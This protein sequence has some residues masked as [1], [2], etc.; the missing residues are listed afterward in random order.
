MPC[1][2]DP[3]TTKTL[4]T[5]LYRV[6]SMPNHFLETHSFCIQS[7]IESNEK[8]RLY[9]VIFHG[10]CK[11]P[12]CTPTYAPNAHCLHSR[13]QTI[14]IILSILLSVLHQMCSSLV[15]PQVLCTPTFTL[16]CTITFINTFD[17]I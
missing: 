10:L 5:W 6:Q 1:Y 15:W 3:S 7:S 9:T 11:A 4:C 13:R 16:F 2:G 17:G 12:A 8:M 14:F